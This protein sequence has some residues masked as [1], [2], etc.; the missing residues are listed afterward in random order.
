MYT[1]CLFVQFQFPVRS[2]LSSS[3]KSQLYESSL[4]RSNCFFL[5]RHVTSHVTLIWPTRR[6][7]AIFGEDLQISFSDR[8]RSK[9]EVWCPWFWTCTKIFLSHFPWN[10]PILQGWADFIFS[11]DVSI[12]SVHTRGVSGSL[13]RSCGVQNTVQ[14]FADFLHARRYEDVQ[15]RYFGPQALK[16]YLFKC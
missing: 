5:I 14:G 4:S 6:L 7:L 16:D 13:S 8:R 3:S 9:A 10:F 1:K 2:P 15:I 12:C 11:R